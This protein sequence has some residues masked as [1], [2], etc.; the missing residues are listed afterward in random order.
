[1]PSKPML[2]QEDTY[3]KLKDLK[4]G[5]RNS[6]TDVIEYLFDENATLKKE[7]IKLSKQLQV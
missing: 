3:N 2:I 6:F 7:Y 4:N 1:M 5:D